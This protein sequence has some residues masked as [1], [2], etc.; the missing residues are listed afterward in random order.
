MIKQAIEDLGFTD[1]NVRI[2]LNDFEYDSDTPMRELIIC[3]VDKE[4]GIPTQ[5]LVLIRKANEK[6][7]LEVF[8]DSR[9]ENCI[10]VLVW[11]SSENEDYTDRFVINKREFEEDEL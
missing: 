9:V 2:E 3:L 1:V 5:D 7:C 8:N 10:E 6:Y 4:T 11:G